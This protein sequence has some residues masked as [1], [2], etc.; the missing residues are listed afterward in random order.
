MKILHKN[1]WKM[2]ALIVP[3]TL[4]GWLIFPVGTITYWDFIV[5]VLLINIWDDVMRIQDKTDSE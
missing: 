1:W 3:A 2:L 5:G 4:V